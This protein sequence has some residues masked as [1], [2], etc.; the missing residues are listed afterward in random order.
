MQNYCLH[1][2]FMYIC[3]V[4]QK[5]NTNIM[6]RAEDTRTFTEIWKG[7][8]SIQ[9]TELKM[10]LFQRAYISA[11]AVYGWGISARTPK[12]ANKLLL[13]EALENKFNIRTT[14]ETLFPNR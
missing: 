4:I 14:P 13:V 10:A 6:K 8:D 11:S 7:L 3:T 9:K 1:K 12:L 2:L 5:Y